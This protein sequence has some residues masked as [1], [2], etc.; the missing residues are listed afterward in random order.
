MSGHPCDAQP[1]SNTEILTGPLL[2]YIYGCSTKRKSISLHW[3]FMFTSSMYRTASMD[4][5][6]ALLGRIAELVDQRRL[7]TTVG[8]HFGEIGADTLRRA[9]KLIESNQAVGKIV[10]G[11]FPPEG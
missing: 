2:R 8:E 11:G 9:H 3:E 5:Q 1:A 7:R 6:H 10:L 4:K